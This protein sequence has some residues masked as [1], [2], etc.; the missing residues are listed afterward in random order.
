MKWLGFGNNGVIPSNNREQQR[1]Y[2][3]YNHLVANLLVLHNTDAMTRVLQDLVDEGY[4]ITNNIAAYLSPHR[5]EHVNRFGHLDLRL[6][7]IPPPL[8]TNFKPFAFLYLLYS[9]KFYT[10]V[11]LPC[12]RIRVLFLS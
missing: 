5:T 10:F 3:R 2:V 7:R 8:Q 11:C 1:R 12:T 6:D 9:L 4:H